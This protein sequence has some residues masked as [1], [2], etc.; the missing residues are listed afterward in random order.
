[1]VEDFPEEVKSQGQAKLTAP[2]AWH[3]VDIRIGEEWSE[4]K[5]TDAELLGTA[6]AMH[7]LLVKTSR[8][9]I[10]LL[11]FYLPISPEPARAVRRELLNEIEQQ[12]GTCVG[13]CQWLNVYGG[14]EGS[15][16][17][18]LLEEFSELFDAFKEY[19]DS[20][21]LLRHECCLLIP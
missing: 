4:V 14:C 6:G 2:P 19:E 13:Y 5:P 1:M 20:I 15:C 3:P 18:W 12:L 16:V 11:C 21:I 7:R 10:K 9:V 17:C 8:D